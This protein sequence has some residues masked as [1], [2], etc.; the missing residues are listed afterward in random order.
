MRSVCLSF[1]R[2]CLA[3]WVGI[4]IFFVAL[5]IELR[6]SNLFPEPIKFNHPRVLFPLYY[7]F[8]F[9]LLGT[10]LVAAAV[11]AWSGTAGAARRRALLGLI[12][13]AILL[14]VCDYGLVY[15]A[16][17]DMMSAAPPD[18]QHP[19]VLPPKFH[20]LHKISRWLNGCILILTAAGALLSLRA[21]RPDGRP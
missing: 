6:Q 21:D 10:A 15:G 9:G 17:V 12:L 20:E 18:M 16:L 5:V 13:V 7:G 2:F 19:P 11:C 8:E 1:V 3:A 4:A 14:A